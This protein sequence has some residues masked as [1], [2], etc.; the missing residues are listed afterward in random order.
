MWRNK[1]NVKRRETKMIPMKKKKKMNK[2]YQ[3]KEKIFSHQSLKEV[4]LLSR[5]S[6]RS[7]RNLFQEGKEDNQ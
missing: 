4:F 3:E 1:A 2:T 6:Q 7:L 5:K